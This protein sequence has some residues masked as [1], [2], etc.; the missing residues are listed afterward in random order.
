MSNDISNVKNS[1]PLYHIFTRIPDRYD[2]INHVITLG[3]DGGWR[4]R[5]ALECLKDRPARILDICCGTGDLSITIAKLAQYNPEITG[6]D[7]SQPMLEIAAAKA[8]S[9]ASEKSIHFINA[10]VS[11]LPFADGYFDC[12]GISFAFRNLTYQNPLTQSYIDEVRRVLKPGGKFVIVESCQPQT[13]FIRFFDHLYLRGWVF[14]TGYILSGNK[15]AYRYLAE[16]ALHFYSAEEMQEF[17][18]KAG[19]KQATANRLFFGAAAIYTAVK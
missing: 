5:T 14:P 7:Y 16:S 1:R 18:L 13:T 9:L 3:M 6:A 19:F 17:L 8:Q 11:H 15:G 2:L 10:D 12:I 4:R